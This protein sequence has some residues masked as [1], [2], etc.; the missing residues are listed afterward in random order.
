MRAFVAV[1]LSAHVRSALAVLQQDLA[2]SNADVKWV[3]PPHL[4]VT[5]KFLGE[6]TDDERRAVETLLQ[7]VADE[8][9][10]F[11]LTLEELGAFPSLAAPRVLWVGIREGKE[12]VV[13]LA[14]AI[15]REG[16]AIPLSKDERP[17]AAHVTLGRVR[18]PRHRQALVQRLRDAACPPTKDFGGGAWRTPDPLRVT[19]LTLYQ[20][21][22][23]PA[24]PRYT[25]LADVPLGGR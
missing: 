9:P 10:P 21:V 14:E 1:D 12:Q 8:T 25:V 6:I 20:S 2:R 13:R 23:G 17:F 3:E 11:T 4:H 18:S 19:T 7:R 5:L 16:A 22:L 15:E 24:G